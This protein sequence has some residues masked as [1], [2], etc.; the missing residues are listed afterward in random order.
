MW[1]QHVPR[2]QNTAATAPFVLV[3]EGALQDTLSNGAWRDNASTSTPCRGVPSA[4][5]QRPPRRYD[6]STGDMVVAWLAEDHLLRSGHR[7]SASAPTFGGYP[8]CKSPLTAAPGLASTLAKSQTDAMG[9]YEFLAQLVDASARRIRP[10]SARL[11][12][13]SS[14]FLV[15][16]PTRGGSF[17]VSSWLML[18]LAGTDLIELDSG[19][20]IKKV[21]PGTVHSAFCPRYPYYTE[22]IKASKPGQPGC[23]Q[24]L[25]CK[26]IT[27]NSVCGRHGWNNQ[28][29]EN[30]GTLSGL[31][32]NGVGGHCTVSGYPCMA[33]TEKGYPDS[34][35]PF[36][37][38]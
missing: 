1:L 29:P 2:P 12:P 19:L 9:A 32:K 25:G 36:V 33:C 26:G 16:R 27:S 6:I 15:A 18:K 28:Q 14:T 34:F 5:R 35:V 30:T 31:N 22:G 10:R 8:G 37:K 3:L 4:V 11:P 21:Y 38:R 7:P 17:S 23:L 13:R 24:N 20:P